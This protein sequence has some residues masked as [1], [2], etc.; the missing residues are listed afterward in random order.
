MSLVSTHW[1]SEN[2]NKVKIIDSTWHMP[3]EKRNG[4]SEFEMEHIPNAIYFDIDKNSKQETDIPHM[5]TTKDNWERIVS[6]LGISNEDRLVIYDNSDVISSCRC[7]YNFLYF[8]HKK[9]L[10]NILDG[11]LIKWKS[12]N[13][14][15]T[16]EKTF[17]KKSNYIAYENREMVKNIIDINKNIDQVCFKVID[18]RSQDRFDGKIEEPRKGLRSGSIPNSICM[19]YRHVINND[20]TFKKKDKI[21]E[22]FEPIIKDENNINLVF[23][24][25]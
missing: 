5:L 7:W 18:G 2:K 15:L 22:L 17:L 8:G 19:P 12:E 1:L 9:E 20:R 16:Q 6:S 3:K 10:I 14:P 4:F 13:Y 11:G 24:C 23:S 25:G 21:K